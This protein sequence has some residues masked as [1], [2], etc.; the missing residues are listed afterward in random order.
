[1]VRVEVSH[2]VAPA[3]ADHQRD[4]VDVWRGRH[5]REGLS[6]ALRGE[7]GAKVLIPDARERLVGVDVVAPPEAA[8]AFFIAS[9]AVGVRLPLLQRNA[10]RVPAGWRADPVNLGS[11]TVQAVAVA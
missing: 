5:R 10:S 8:N 1:V 2:S 3:A 4:L 7:L 9:G 6:G 11:S